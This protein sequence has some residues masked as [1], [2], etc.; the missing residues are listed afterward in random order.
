[1]NNI[2]NLPSA[3][4]L[5]HDEPSQTESSDDDGGCEVVDGQTIGTVW[6]DGDGPNALRNLE[7]RGLLEESVI[8]RPRLAEYDGSGVFDIYVETGLLSGIEEAVDTYTDDLK[9]EGYQVSVQ[10]FS[11]DAEALKTKLHSRWQE[12]GL[13][14]TLFVGDLP[15][16]EF[17]SEDNFNA[18]SRQVTYPHDL[19]FMDL[20]GDY[21][22]DDFGLDHHTGSV[23]PEIYVSRLTTGNL[24][25]ITG[26]SETD[27]I[28]DY[29]AKNHAYRTG[30]LTFDNRG[31][32]FAD[33]DWSYWGAE[34]MQDLYEEVLALNNASETTKENYLNTLGLN[35]E[36][37]LEAI[38]SS[39]TSHSLKVDGGRE[40]ISSQEI[41]ETNPRAGFYNL[42]NCSSADFTVPNNLIGAYVYGSD[43]GL[44]A[45][46]SAKTGSML[47]FSDFY[48][49][50]GENDSAGQAFLQ[51]F[52]RYAVGTDDPRLDWRVDWFNGMTMQGDPTL[53]PASM[54]DRMSEL[55][56]AK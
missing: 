4:S 35:Y 7:Q 31:I 27:L 49:P 1:M 32:V 9:G 11:G 26:Q 39:P 28:N 50:Q 54:G 55:T 5:P 2:F 46:G 3:K 29:F 17:T 18:S 43:F 30:K 6:L 22:F 44:N 24:S 16:V 34:R 19:Y 36:S 40:R 48:R 13:E 23:S 20:D 42:F 8:P 21:K 37:I 52:D 12:K 56:G 41:V 45:I 10:E 14:G 53:K 15:H 33:D 51:W 47:Y 38:H 25:A